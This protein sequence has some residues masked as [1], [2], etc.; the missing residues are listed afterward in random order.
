MSKLFFLFASFQANLNNKK[1]IYEM[2]H[3]YIPNHKKRPIFIFD[4]RLF[5]IFD[6]IIFII[7]FR[8]VYSVHD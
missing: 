7:I 5:Q 1:K 8:C 4:S 2:I 6:G 3:K